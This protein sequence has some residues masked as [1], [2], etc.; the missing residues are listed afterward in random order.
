M[1]TQQPAAADDPFLEQVRLLHRLRALNP[2]LTARQRKR[3]AERYGHIGD[4]PFRAHP[5]QIPAAGLRLRL[6]FDG[7]SRLWQ[8]AGTPKRTPFMRKLMAMRSVSLTTGTTFDNAANLAP[9]YLDPI[10]ERYASTRLGRQ[11]LYGELIADP[12]NT[13]FKEEWLKVASVERQACERVVVGVDPSLGADEVGTVVVA[14]TEDFT[15]AI[16]A[17]HS[18]RRAEGWELD[19]IRAYDD[20]AA[21]LSG[22][23]ADISESSVLGE[24]GDVCQSEVREEAI[25]DGRIP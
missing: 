13:M 1:A 16:L 7:R 19:V 9:D 25:G 10:R 12:E 4:W 22:S 6:A 21:S 14:L 18:V 23:F 17:D 3:N 24:H 8:D 20:F 5:G 11:E 15:Y 2:W